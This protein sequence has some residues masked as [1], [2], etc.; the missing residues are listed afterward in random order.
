MPDATVC[1]LPPL[2]LHPFTDHAGAS[3]LVENSRSNLALHG[4]APSNGVSEEE[5][6]NRVSEARITEMRMLFYVGKDLFRWIGQCMDVAARAPEWQNRRLREQSFAGLLVD[7]TPPEVRDKLRG[8][9]VADYALLFSRAMG[10]HTIFR[11]PPES[12][13][14]SDEFV[15]NYHRYADAV[16]ACFQES[17]AHAEIGPED[18]TFDLYGSREYSDLLEQQWGGAT[19]GF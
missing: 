10:L 6:A 3:K 2:I 17:Q 8:W 19:D 7:R 5:L 13:D 9:G 12:A 4:L 15:I 14:L 11:R 18:F 16:F 1:K